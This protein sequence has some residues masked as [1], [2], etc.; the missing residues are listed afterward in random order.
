MVNQNVEVNYSQVNESLRP[1]F[2][3]DIKIQMRD[4]IDVPL[5]KEGNPDL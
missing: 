4:V 2:R 1:L 3:N 5:G